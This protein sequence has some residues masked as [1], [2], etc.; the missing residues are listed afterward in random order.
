MTRYYGDFPA[1]QNLTLEAYPGEIFGFLGANGAGKT[2]TIR[3]ITGL[4]RPTAGRVLVKGEDLWQP[5]TERRRL[6]GYVPDTPLVYE[7][8]TA[9]EHLLAVGRLYNLSQEK[10]KEKI[11]A[12]LSMFNLESWGDQMLSTYSM[13]MRRKFSL[14]LALLP[15]PELI[16]IDELTNAFDAPT[17]AQI[18]DIL[19]GLRERGKTVFISTHVMDVAEKLCNRVGIIHRGQLKALGTVE[20]LC[21]SHRV[22]G[23]LEPLFLKIVT[24][25]EAE[26]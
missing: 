2:T 26:K 13:G 19:N 7:R 8:L 17:L 21:R 1:V 15:D 12:I 10:L 22:A 9:R 16:I 23:G 25:K 11:E 14:A 18:K 5:G 3:M 6:I 4:L 20:A 24:G